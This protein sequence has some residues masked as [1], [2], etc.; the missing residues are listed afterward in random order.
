MFE[1]WLNK[2]V[3]VMGGWNAIEKSKDIT[4][5]NQ[6]LKRIHVADDTFSKLAVKT[7]TRAQYGRTSSSFVNQ[8][9]GLLDLKPSD[10]FVDIGSGIG[11]VVFQVAGTIGCDTSG[12]EICAGR[13]KFAKMLEKRFASCFTNKVR[14]EHGDFRAPDNFEL[15][16]N[17]TALFVNNANGIFSNR[18]STSSAYSLDWHI[19]RLICGLSIGSRIVCYD[20]LPELDT[21]PFSNCFTKTSHCSA[22]GS[23]SWTE[24]SQSVTKFVVYIKTANEWICRQ[25][26]SS[27]PCLKSKKCDYNETLNDSCATCIL[28]GGYKRPYPM[29]KRMKEMV[30]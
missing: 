4:D 30:K 15:A 27:N 25:C 19:A 22:A 1:I 2:E 14:L 7:Q 29:R 16:R 12:I 18:S 9:V 6:S 3:D 8:I 10:K 26:K 11:T 24:V 23:T 20:S 28:S 13:H 5:G 21:L 17:A